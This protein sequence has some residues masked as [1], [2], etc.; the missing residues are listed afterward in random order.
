MRFAACWLRLRVAQPHQVAGLT[1][2]TC[3]I[4]QSVPATFAVPV[5]SRTQPL[6]VMLLASF[7]GLVLATQSPCV[8]PPSFGITA[9]SVTPPLACK[10]LR[11]DFL[12]HANKLRLKNNHTIEKLSIFMLRTMHLLETYQFHRPMKTKTPRVK[13]HQPQARASTHSRFCLNLTP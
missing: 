10:F 8:H 7:V 4:A 2:E 12:L 9:A 1:C 11:N 13:P 6:T 3:A 5:V